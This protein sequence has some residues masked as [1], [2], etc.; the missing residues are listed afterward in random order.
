MHPQWLTS[1][2]DLAGLRP[3]PWSPAPLLPAGHTVSAV[4]AVGPPFHALGRVTCRAMERHR[5]SAQLP[6]T[7]TTGGSPA[8]VPADQGERWESRC[9][10]VGSSKSW[11]AQAAGPSVLSG[12]WMGSSEAGMATG[13]VGCS[14]PGLC[15]HRAGRGQQQLFL[16]L[17]LGV[18]L[19]ES[20]K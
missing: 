15:L 17:S 6:G 19:M 18:S 10:E 16:G 1:G 3:A 7:V 13:I 4:H 11:D 14:L 5:S 8:R 12:D 20:V 9:G 2:G